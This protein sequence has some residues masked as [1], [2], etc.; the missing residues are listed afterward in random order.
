MPMS[1]WTRTYFTA[2][3]L[4]AWQR[5]QTE[6]ITRAEVAFLADALL[7]AEEPMHLLDVPC[8]EARHAVE[9]A[10]LGHRLTGV[11][12]APDN[13]VR[14]LAR[15]T[16]AGVS[17]EHVLGDMRELPAMPVLDGAYCWGNS[18][19]YFPRAETQR[20]AAAVANSLRPGARF[21]IDTATAAESLLVELNRRSW[22]PVDD[23][24]TLLLECEY[25]ARESRLDTTYISLLKDTVVDRRTAHHF[26][27]TSGEIV[28]MLDVAGFETL[29]LLA[30]LDG[31][32]YELGSERLLLIA[33]RR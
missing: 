13:Q 25:D 15:A 17:L 28:G 5:A 12:I 26:V 14:A 4:D 3:A 22:V 9:L 2:P 31:S 18:F 27:F 29:A 32:E 8:G 10:K 11:D 1:N 19:G 30:D 21:I 6:E 7:A 20:F 16:A 33:E 24:L 23:E